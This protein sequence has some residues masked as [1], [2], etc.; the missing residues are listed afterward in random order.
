MGATLR[1][2]KIIF[3]SSI[4]DGPGIRTVVFFQGCALRCEGCHNPHTW[5]FNSGYEMPIDQLF[6][7]LSD[8]CINRKITLSGGEPLLQ[9]E[10]L[11][12]LLELLKENNFD[13]AL[14]TGYEKM[15]EELLKYLDYIKL[16]PFVKELRT[17]TTPFI[18]SS[19]QVFINLKE[20]REI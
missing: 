2:N 18:G 3:N 12:K 1:L 6:K 5:D 11:R 9:Y 20:K 7:T 17:T 15:P 14:Y 19:N 16:G 13:I 4:V 10:G 8:N